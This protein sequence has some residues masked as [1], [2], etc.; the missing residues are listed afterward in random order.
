MQRSYVREIAVGQ[1]FTG[2]FHLRAKE[3]RT[4][5]AGETYL[6]M[7]LAD[8]TG[9]AD[10]VLFRPDA[11]ALAT[12]V[13]VVVEARGQLSLYRGSRRLVL[14][15]LALAREW[16]SED[17][18]PGGERPTDELLSELRAIA[19]SIEHRTLRGVVRAVFGDS[20]FLK[21]FQMCPATI[22]DHHAHLG[23]LLEHT[24]AVAAFCHAACE[25]YPHVES[26]ILITAA[27]CHDV[28]RVDEI[29]FES[30]IS[31]NERGRLLGHV[32]LGLQRV[33]DETRDRAST[34]G[35]LALVEH[36]ML[37][38][39]GAA[40][41]IEPVTIEA[42]VLAQA[43]MFDISAARAVAATGIAARAGERWTDSAAD[44]KRPG[45]PSVGARH[46]SGS[47]SHT[48][49]ASRVVA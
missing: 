24:V 1:H 45:R 28:G 18:M 48:A 38:H 41:G 25:R 43:D 7:R 4:T 46:A 3:V 37:T 16:A 13:G 14:D 32:A 2:V 23:G 6:A 15:S 27:L 34:G 11:S 44:H 40:H 12:P 33:R 5:R 22:E 29:S 39:H 35:A 17:L 31:V 30:L 10:A 8:R 20:S 47:Q 9:S 26:D 19:A 36:A 42:M 49:P 21:A